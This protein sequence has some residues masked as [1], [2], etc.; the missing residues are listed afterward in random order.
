MYKIAVKIKETEGAP[1]IIV[2]WDKLYTL[3]W[4]AEML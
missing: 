2:G 4:S 3:E 1:C